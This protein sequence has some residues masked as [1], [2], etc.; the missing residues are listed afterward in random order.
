MIDK[1][2][3]CALVLALAAIVV[4]DSALADDRPSKVGDTITNSIGMK[5]TYIPAGEF[6]MGSP[7]NEE[8]RDD[9]E[10]QHKV[11][12]S[13]PFLMGVTEVT[14]GQY[15]AVMGKNPSYFDGSDDLPVEKVSWEDAVEFCEKLSKK[16]GRTYRLPTEAE[17]EYA[18]RAGTTTAFNVGDRPS[19]DLMNYNG[20]YTYNGSSRGVDRGKTVSVGSFK[21][22][23][24]GLYDMH[25]N[26]YEWCSDWYG[27]YPKGAVTDPRG[28]ATGRSRVLR[29]GCWC[30]VP[31]YCRSANRDRITPVNR[32]VYGGFRVSLDLSE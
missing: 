18:C 20:D 6:L 7:R 23:R 32:N 4:S 16:E 21:P 14:Q 8:R 12:I 1:L 29:G 5:L 11:K 22:N 13:K 27:D 28:P 31:R 3:K 24:W 26:V 15:K 17:W 30:H 25:G 10:T 9:D 19:V 2:L